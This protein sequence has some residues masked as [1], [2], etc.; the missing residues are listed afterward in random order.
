MKTILWLPF[1]FAC[2]SSD[3]EPADSETTD[4]DDSAAD[5]ADSTV[6]TADTDGG[7]YEV[8]I[9]LVP[10]AVGHSSTKLDIQWGEWSG[11]HVVITLTEDNGPPAVIE[12]SQ[13]SYQVDG[14]KSDTTYTASLE[15][16]PDQACT[17]PVEMGAAS[18][19]TPEETWQF[20][21][22]G[23]TLSGLA[24]VVSDGNAN[25]WGIW[26]GDDAPEDQAG[27]VQLY[28]GPTQGNGVNGQAVGVA[29]S[30][31]ADPQ[32]L[33]TLYPMD[34][35]HGTAG[36]ISPNPATTWISGIMTAQAVPLSSGIIRLYF[37]ANGGDGHTRILSIDSVDGY[38]GMDFNADAATVCS[39]NADYLDNG[40]C[41]STLA[42][43]VDGDSASAVEN[44]PNVRQFKIAYP[45]LTDWRWDESPGTFMFFTV[46]GGGTCGYD[47]FA[48]Q[49]YAI[50]DG[51][52]WN[53]V[54]GE[55]GCPV[56]LESM[57][58]PAPVHLGGVKYKLYH[59]D[60][61][62][63]TGAD[64]GSMLPFLGPKQL[65]YGD[66]VSTGAGATVE[67][68]DW[69]PREAARGLTFLW[70]D[71]TAMDAGEEGYIDDFVFMTPTGTTDF[72]VAYVVLTDGMQMP[73]P[74][75]AILT[76][77]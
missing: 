48:N 26:Y 24:T 62:D 53:P 57:Q 9:S 58:A 61:S 33:S 8:T 38:V 37:E 39:T 28:Y 14:L 74:A 7:V 35:N 51:S 3:S 42:L 71:G 6:D 72:Q 34:A 66:G 11:D 41:P 75:F 40:G 65:L 44:I 46:D 4:S 25:V 77:P 60:P 21:G 36:L 1:L 5:T 29:T 59:G 27:R 16:C 22:T 52:S 30:D 64:E 63:R 55:D 20:S 76:N 67:F 2:T 49:A 73:R 47:G 32:D 12:T 69:E 15:L 68:E 56:A 45:T 50:W 19:T 13:S 10:A 54:Y 31:V 43:G 18:A 23:N 17:A 70:P